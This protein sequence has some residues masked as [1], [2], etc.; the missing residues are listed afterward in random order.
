MTRQVAWVC[1]LLAATACAR[2]AEV[3]N[4][5]GE[6]PSETAPAYAGVPTPPPEDAAHFEGTVRAVRRHPKSHYRDVFALTDSNGKQTAVVT[7]PRSAV[8]YVQSS[9]GFEVTDEPAESGAHADVWTTEPVFLEPVTSVE[10]A[11]I[12]VR[13]DD[14]L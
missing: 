12:I 14:A 6:T 5:A 9:D 11:Y 2:Q 8:V 7:V 10:A 13:Q 1:I 4:T 3:V